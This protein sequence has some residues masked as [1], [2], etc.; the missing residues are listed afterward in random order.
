VRP[1][2]SLPAGVSL[3][4]RTHWLV[5]CR[6]GAGPVTGATQEQ[7][8]MAVGLCD[9]HLPRRRNADG[10][11]PVAVRRWALTRQALFNN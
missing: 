10:G 8:A 9:L 7:T 1:E 4:V 3:P 5:M 11:P 2:R 6:N